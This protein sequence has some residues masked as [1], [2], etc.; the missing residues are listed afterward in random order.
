LLRLGFSAYA[1]DQLGGQVRR[2]DP[3]A[4][5][6]TTGHAALYI[7]K[8]SKAEHDAEEWQ[9]AMEALILVAECGGPTRFA[10][11]GVMRVLQRHEA[12]A[13]STPR[14]KQGV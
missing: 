7:T 11:I 1:S 4:E 3:A 6:Q 8:L 9:A 14:R 5:R 13:A 10:R 12:K 2:T